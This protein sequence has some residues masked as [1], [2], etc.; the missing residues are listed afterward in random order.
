M[1]SK[2]IPNEMQN[3]V[4]RW[5]DYSWKYGTIRGINDVSNLGMMPE[6]L[7]VELAI[8]MNL[9]TLRKVIK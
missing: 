3:R 5:Y 1:K 8:H 2:N 6:T 9:N 4:L 7:K